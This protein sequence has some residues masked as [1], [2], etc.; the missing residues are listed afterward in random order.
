MKLEKPN[1]VLHG[2]VSSAPGSAIQFRGATECTRRKD[3][4]A[5]V[6]PAGVPIDLR[7]DIDGYV[8]LYAFDVASMRGER[9]PLAFTPIRGA[10]M[11]G[12]VQTS[13]GHPVSG[14]VISVVP[15]APG[16]PDQRLPLRTLTTRTNT[17]GF[18]Q[19]AG[20]AEGEYSVMS[21]VAGMSVARESILY[22]R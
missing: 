10:S 3:I 22:R 21:R 2:V 18:F 8:P 7:F 15:D 9:I 4:Y 11:A 19:L 12:S 5:C 1:T 6:I 13:D 16:S 14:A 20:V 17:R